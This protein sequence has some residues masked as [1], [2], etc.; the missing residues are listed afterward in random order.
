[1]S[2]KIE[3]GDIPYNYKIFLD[4]VKEAEG[5]Y[6]HRNPKE[7]NLTNSYGIYAGS[8]AAKAIPELWDY[9]E[10]VAKPLTSLPM[11]KWSPRLI[12]RIEPLVDD[13]V[14]RY[15]SYKFYEKYLEGA[16][17]HL[18]SKD[19]VLVMG[20]LY[21][22]SP[23]GAWKSVQEA[24]RDISK[25]NILPIEL[26]ELSIVDGKFGPKTER[27]LREFDRI[28]DWKDRIIFKK[29]ILLAMKTYYSELIARNADKFLI[30]IRGWNHR[31]EELE[32]VTYVE[33]K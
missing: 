19:L 26:K 31:I 4:H 9:L 17:L 22:N 2:A 32:H 25:D 5:G 1:M 21:T 29:S 11:H 15:L 16:R 13:E 18:F 8:A 3:I 27:A 6:I 14:E 23:L 30:N 33:S 12:S 28:A 7:I 24:L 10:D 20:N